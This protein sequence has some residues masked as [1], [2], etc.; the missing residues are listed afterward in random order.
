MKKKLKT[1]Y[2]KH[3]DE[4]KGFND[5]IMNVQTEREEKIQ[6][7]VDEI[8]NSPPQLDYDLIKEI[9]PT[10]KQLHHDLGKGNGRKL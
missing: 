2:K 5:S 10:L 6:A 4:E 1:L 7:A 8:A 9:L 3:E